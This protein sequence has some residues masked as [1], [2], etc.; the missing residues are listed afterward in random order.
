MLDLGNSPG[1]PRVRTGR[2]P[3][4]RAG[5][6]G[7]VGVACLVGA[8]LTA[9][10]WW[11]VERL[12]AWMVGFGPS[13]GCWA[14]TV[15]LM[16]R[17][18]GASGRVRT[19]LLLLAGSAAT[20]CVYRSAVDLLARAP[21]WG[22][23]TR[24]LSGSLVVTGVTMTIGLGLAGLLVAAD[25]GTGRHM[26]LRRVLDG[27]VAAGS[28]FMMGWLLLRGVGEGWR[29]E[30][31]MVGVL[32]AAEVVFLGFLV[33]LR[34]LVQSG[35]QV[36]VW[37]AVAGLSLTLVGD[38]LR[39]WSAGRHVPGVASSRLACACVTAGL[40]VV[41]IGPWVPGG[42]SVLDAGRPTP[43]QGMDGAAAFIVLTVCTVTA[44]GFALAPLACDPVP[45]LVGGTV[46]LGLWA[47]RTLLPSEKTGRND[48]APGRL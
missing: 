48:R 43:Q 29:L 14:L 44:L 45:L 34:R 21:A 28:V 1:V 3:R 36:T 38:T 10:G 25:A 42:A 35:Q 46:L 40:L 22:L 31:G 17:G 24:P 13:L 8:A 33:A 39:L 11:V 15:S 47:R 37:V 16:L 23:D 41:A 5:V 6:W 20:G 19:R 32:W 18:R 12:S 7:A 9:T 27:I 2:C 30:T 4:S 26:W